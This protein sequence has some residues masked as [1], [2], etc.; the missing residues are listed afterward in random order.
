MFEE[1]TDE[2]VCACAKSAMSA[3]S[4]ARANFIMAFLCARI[5][6]RCWLAPDAETLAPIG[7]HARGRSSARATSG[8][9]AGF[10]VSKFL[11]IGW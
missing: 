8:S 5:G 9:L 11:P 1:K 4:A 2:I 10:L 3:A 7:G 6:G